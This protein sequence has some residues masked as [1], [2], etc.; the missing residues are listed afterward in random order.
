MDFA[1]ELVAFATA[2]LIF[3]TAI[4]EFLT[5]AQDRPRRKKKSR[6]R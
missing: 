1:T 4:V 2:L 3:A 6:K 5:K